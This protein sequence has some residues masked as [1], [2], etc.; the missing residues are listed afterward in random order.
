MLAAHVD[1]AHDRCMGTEPSVLQE[2]MTADRL[3]RFARA[4]T[5][6]DLD[7]LRTI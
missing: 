2:R 7:V 5:C 3:D 4:W 6:C 1:V